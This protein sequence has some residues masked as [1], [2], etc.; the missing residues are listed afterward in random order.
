MSA[1]NDIT[2]VDPAGPAPAGIGRRA[3]GQVVRGF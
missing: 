1:L 3:V 2:T